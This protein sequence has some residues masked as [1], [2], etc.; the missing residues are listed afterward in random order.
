[1]ALC[2]VLLVAV[3]ERDRIG[4]RVKEAIPKNRLL[5]MT[6]FPFF[7]GAASGI[8]WTLSM[9]FLMI[10]TSFL[11]NA[12]LWHGKSFINSLNMLGFFLYVY[13][14]T[15]SGMLIRKHALSRWMKAKDTWAVALALFAAGHFIPLI[16]FGFFTG[17]GFVATDQVLYGNA[18]DLL[19]N[20]DSKHFVFMGIW[21]F[22]LTIMNAG[23]FIRQI[24]DFKP[25]E[26]AAK[27]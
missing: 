3:S 6:V 18:F 9:S 19:K 24:R 10:L 11:L 25:P 23:W 27:S 21:A 13:C 2:A 4:P 15:L 17:A 20:N 8:T 22:V 5:R 1:M 7:S 16:I 26:T 14:Y 12:R